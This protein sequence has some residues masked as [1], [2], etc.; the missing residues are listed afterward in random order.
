M[1]TLAARLAKIPLAMA[2]ALQNATRRQ[3]DAVHRIGFAEGKLKWWAIEKPSFLAFH[4][5]GSCRIRHSVSQS[6]IPV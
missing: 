1:N 2:P 3:L 4:S 5:A 6:R